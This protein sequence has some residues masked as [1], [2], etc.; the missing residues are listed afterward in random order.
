MLKIKIKDIAPY[1]LFFI[2]LALGGWLFVSNMALRD[3]VATLQKDKSGLELER[4]LLNTNIDSL[5]SEYKSL[6]ISGQQQKVNLAISEQEY[7]ILKNQYNKLRNTPVTAQKTLTVSELDSFW[8]SK[9]YK[10]SRVITTTDTVASFTIKSEREIVSD[11]NQGVH[12][13][14]QLALANTL[15]DSCENISSRKDKYIDNLQAKNDNLSAQ[16]LYKD[17]LT[18]S[19]KKEAESE[20]KANKKLTRRRDAWK[21]TSAGLASLATF[22]LIFK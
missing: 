15:I 8:A 1:I 9:S 19:Y 13:T 7:S 17:K 21:I 14:S 6:E 22:I 20:K 18:T 12:S 10:P 5:I 3:K 2:C 11:L 16:I 4:N